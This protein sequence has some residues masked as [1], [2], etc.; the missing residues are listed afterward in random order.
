M[1]ESLSRGR[2]GRGRK[3]SERGEHKISISTS[4]ER[5]SMVRM[6]NLGQESLI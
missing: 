3:S 4:K 5:I 1:L 2:G 6:K